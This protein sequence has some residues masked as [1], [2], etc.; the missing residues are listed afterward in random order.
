MVQRTS[1]QTRPDISRT[2][3]VSRDGFPT[4]L[5]TALTTL[6]G[7]RSVSTRRAVIKRRMEMAAVA[8]GFPQEAFGR[9]TSWMTLTRQDV[10][11]VL[12]I[13]IR[14]WERQDPN[15]IITI[16]TEDATYHERVLEA[17]IQNRDA[18]RDYWHTKVVESQANIKCK[19]LSLYLDGTT[20]IAEWEAEFDDPGAAG[21]ETYARDRGAGVRGPSDRR[22]S[23]VLGVSARRGSH[24]GL[25][26]VPDGNLT[27]GALG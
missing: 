18:I 2:S 23:G 21:T 26:S 27:S 7:L 9:E 11:D 12:D 8:L 3:A 6:V 10:R 19:L 13:Y 16:F 17:P 22:S 1:G 20:A 24:A 25:S 15:L 5:R 14:A 4:A